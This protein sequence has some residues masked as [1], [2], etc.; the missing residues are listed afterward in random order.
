MSLYVS[1]IVLALA[2][3][4]SPCGINA[5]FV[6]L[7]LGAIRRNVKDMVKSAVLFV[8]G[9]VS[10]N[11]LLGGALVWGYTILPRGAIPWMNL[12]L[13][14]LGMLLAILTYLDAC[15]G[16]KGLTTK[17]EKQ[18]IKD[19]LKKATSPL[20]AYIVGV[21]LA[22]LIM[23]CSM[24]PYIMFAVKISTIGSGLLKLWYLVLFNVIFSLPFFTLIALLY[25]AHTIRY[26]KKLKSQYMPCLQTITSFLI[27]LFAY[28][29]FIEGWNAL[30]GK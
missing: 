12:I 11:L 3:A 15:R 27:A 4:M 10:G 8:L 23:P 18:M 16:S 25:G 14:L 6:L 30:F 24:G 17:G 21:L 20:L 7:T 22:L 28:P 9:V 29:L 1:L 13:G 5:I 19:Y 2:S 26:V